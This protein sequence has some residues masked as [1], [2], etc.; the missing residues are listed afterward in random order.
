M[1]Y[2]QWI[3]IYFVSFVLIGTFIIF[4]LFIGVIVNN[5]EKANDSEEEED[6]AN[7]QVSVSVSELKRIE[8]QL[9]S[10]QAELKKQNHS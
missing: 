7:K 9:E 3:W 8:Q 6:P 2:N 5:V 4:N 1:A 10:I